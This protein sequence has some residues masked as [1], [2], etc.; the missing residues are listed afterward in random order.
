MDSM[1]GDA[2]EAGCGCLTYLGTTFIASVI[3]LLGFYDFLKSLLGSL[4]VTLMF[5]PLW[6]FGIVP[7][8]GQ[9]AYKSFA[10]GIIDWGLGLLQIDPNITLSVPDWIDFIFTWL[11]ETDIE[12]TLHS[13]VYAV[14]YTE[15]IGISAVVLIK[16]LSAIFKEAGLWMAI[17][18]ILV[19]FVAKVFFT[20]PI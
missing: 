6:L 9:L 5:V 4:A 13:Y 14:G 3:T 17:I 2:G 19:Y 15:V 8:G 12:G 7:I 1:E 10:P 11:L 20:L 18:L 16:G